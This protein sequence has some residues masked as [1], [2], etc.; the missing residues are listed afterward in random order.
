MILGTTKGWPEPL[1]LVRPQS[2]DAADCAQTCS[3][4]LRFIAA[5][6][7]ALQPVIYG[8]TSASI[9]SFEQLDIYGFGKQ[10]I[11]GAGE[12]L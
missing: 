10:F 1:Y 5:S 2:Q 7:H 11:I 3:S 6:D 4:S 12:S 9:N 8:L